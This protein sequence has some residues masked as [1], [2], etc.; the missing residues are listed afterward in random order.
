MSPFDPFADLVLQDPAGA[1]VPFRDL[2]GDP[3]VVILVRYFGCLP[4][5]AYLQDVSDARDR[6]PAEAGIVAIGGSTDFQARWLIEQG[7]TLPLL[8]DPEQQVRDAVG[9]GNLRPWQFASPRGALAYARAMR[10]GLRPQKITRDTV[11]SPG[12]VLLD[13][14]HQ[15]VWAHEGDRLGG[16]PPIDDLLEVVTAHGRTPSGPGA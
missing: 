1:P 3:L 9:F 15:V 6:F 4:C 8:L 5:Q 16:Y 2:Q 14:D 11:R 7:I 10:R 12:V 13:E